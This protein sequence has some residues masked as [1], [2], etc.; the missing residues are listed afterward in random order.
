MLLPLRLA[1]LAA[2]V[3]LRRASS[4]IGRAI[5]VPSGAAIL[6]P[7]IAR[8]AVERRPPQDGWPMRCTLHHDDMSQISDVTVWEPVRWGVVVLV[9]L[10]D[11]EGPGDVWMLP[12]SGELVTAAGIEGLKA[13]REV[14]E[15]IRREAWAVEMAGEGL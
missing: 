2:M 15:T 4:A 11:P 5:D 9:H 7:G 14:L 13:D 1:A 3:A 8:W 6:R 12:A 10:W